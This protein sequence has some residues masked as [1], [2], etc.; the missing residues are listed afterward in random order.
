MGFD[1]PETQLYT[2]GFAFPDFIV[3]S[4]AIF[5]ATAIA[6]FMTYKMEF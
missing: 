5:H 3:L 6:W 1:V 4:L 2:V